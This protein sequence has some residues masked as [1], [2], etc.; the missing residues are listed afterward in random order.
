MTVPQDAR[1]LGPMTLRAIS[2]LTGDQ[3]TLPA[4]EVRSAPGWTP[5]E[6]LWALPGFLDAHRHL[7]HGLADDGA[8]VRAQRD[9]AA[10]ATRAQGVSAVVDMGVEVLEPWPDRPAWVRTALRGIQGPSEGPASRFAATASG[11]R[12]CG[13]L[14]HRTADAGADLIKIFASGTGKHTREI[15]CEQKLTDDMIA[16][17]TREAGARGLAV[18]AH[19]QG[20]PSVRACAEAGVSSLEHGIYLSRQDVETC[21]AAGLSLT[22]TPGVYVAR[23]GEPMR[24]RLRELVRDV[25]D[26]G[27]AF[28]V[29]TDT[30]SQ[31]IA[32][33]VL[34]LIELGMPPLTAISAGTDHGEPTCFLLFDRNPVLEPRRL[35]APVAMAT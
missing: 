22:F 8:G 11:P 12:E 20:G 34:L 27:M 6:E 17:V 14:V 26:T 32:E 30:V 18:A 33:Q 25:L 2:A 35:L 31:T 16:A 5:G 28:R 19:C 13:E 4:R 3:V 9:E 10:A 1:L 24:E 15:A 29:G 23:H 21:A 7:P